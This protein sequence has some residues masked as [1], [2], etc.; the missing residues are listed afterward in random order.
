[1]TKRRMKC[2]FVLSLVPWF[3]PAQAQAAVFDVKSY[4][5]TGDG[6]ALDSPAINRAIEAAAAAGGGTVHFPAGT[7]VTGSIR[8]RSNLTL[9]FEPGTTLEAS[10]D[11]AA[12]DAAE[13]N[14]WD[15]FQDFGHSHFHNSL[16]WGE[17][18]ENVSI[19]GPGLIGGKALER[20]RGA[21]GDKAI[22]LK[23]CRKVTLR[24]FSI[25][26][27][28]HFGILATGVD[29][30]TIDNVTIDTNR[31][32]VDVDSCRNVRISNL[33]VNTP[34]DDAIVLKGTHALGFARPTENVTI[35][36]CLVS[37]YDIGSL[38]DGTY[39]RTVK[40]APDRDGP[41]GRVKI[42][43]ESEGDFRN[44]TISN[45]VFDRSRGL[46]LEAVDGAH[47]EDIA[48]SN[49]T[50]RD[51]S[52]APIFIRLG[53]RMRAPEGT[54]IGSIRRVSISN[55]IAYDADPRYGSI[56][57][58]IPGHDV[59][60]VKL[61]NIRILYRG[62]LNL[63]QVAK[64]PADL[65]NTFFFRASGGVPPRE[66]FDTPERE[67]EYPEPSMFGMLPAYGFF[68]RHAKGIELNDV[69]VGFMQEDRRPAF[70]LDHVND[71]DFQHVKAQKAAGVQTVVLK[72]VENF[73]A[74]DCTPVPDTQIPTV[75]RREM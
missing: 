5:A 62:G 73:T 16:I 54:P 44:I 43:T 9:Q 57:S 52:N 58:G 20:E 40:Q 17:G 29:N 30:L 37:G 14:Q 2:W 22:A 34:N 47:I 24:D 50:M 66:A 13:P 6:K 31:D 4:G 25:L 59:E 1:M 3:V 19:E 71:V 48:V 28:G 12:Y 35:V 70:V 60:D 33:S 51:V 63:D 27:G 69:E 32:G 42:G 18:L 67:K 61:N 49:I 36:N 7:Y 10:A 39:K 75:E 11:P 55:V 74:H 38:L 72:N 26:S 65:V 53:S 23:L 8:L 64:Q 68:I 15:K 46:A 41:T 45:V 56:I 21:D